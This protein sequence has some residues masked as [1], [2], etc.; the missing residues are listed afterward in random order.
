MRYRKWGWVI[1]ALMLSFVLCTAALGEANQTGGTEITIQYG[2]DVIAGQLGSVGRDEQRGLM[3]VSFY[4][5]DLNDHIKLEIIDGGFSI[6]IPIDALISVNGEILEPVDGT[7]YQDEVFWFFDTEKTPDTVTFCPHGDENPANAVTVDA[8]SGIILGVG[9]M[10]GPAVEPEHAAEAQ[11]APAAKANAG[12]FDVSVLLDELCEAASDPW[13]KAIYGAGA[14]WV[15]RDGETVTFALRSFDPNLKSLPGYSGNKQAWLDGFFENVQAYDLEITLILKDDG[16]D[17]DSLRLLKSTV[18][19]AARAS[20]AGFDDKSVRIALVELMLP[21][22]VYDDA[23]AS[24][25]GEIYHDYHELVSTNAAFDGLD[26]V[27]LTPLFYAQSKQVL[28]VKD[29]PHALV[30]NCTGADPVS[31]IEDAYKSVVARLSKVY[32]GNDMSEYEIEEA[33]AEALGEKAASIR[34]TGGEVHAFELDIDAV[35]DGDFGADYTAYMQS[36]DPDSVLW[37][38]VYDV[39][40]M[41]DA[42]A[43]DFPKNGRISGSQSGTKVIVKAPDDGFGRYVQMRNAYTDAMTVDMFIRSGSS[44]TVYVPRGMYY[45]LIA[46]G[47]IW[48]GMEGLFGDGGSYSETD[49]T[50]ILSSE[51]YHTLTLSAGDGDIDVYGS[52]PSAFQN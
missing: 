46:S 17:P 32:K 1:L 40:T 38:L 14:N 5:A 16:P 34:K 8:A 29:G 42:P 25:W 12:G 13:E 26:S 41:P 15:T 10:P 50:E 11:P 43:Q 9:E 37:Q 21:T 47:E 48:Y 24:G 3:G 2:G 36:F 28:S 19:K 30:L 51:Y 22:P 49:E 6:I 20:M 45:L 7:F 44:V 33:F 39:W 52:S 35:I 23:S 27:A 31:L 4:C 18:T